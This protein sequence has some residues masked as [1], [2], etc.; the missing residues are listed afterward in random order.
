MSIFPVVSR[1]EWASAQSRYASFL[2][3]A[4]SCV[5]A[6]AADR[7]FFQATPLERAGLKPVFRENFT[8]GE[9][10]AMRYEPAYGSREQFDSYI[11][12]GA[13][14]LGQANATENTE[15][16]VNYYP[17]SDEPAVWTIEFDAW[18]TALRESR[19][20]VRPRRFRDGV[21]VRIAQPGE[22]T[23]VVFRNEP[24]GYRTVDY[25]TLT[26]PGRGWA[27]VV[28]S[29][30]VDAEKKACEFVSRAVARAAG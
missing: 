22:R 10:D 8:D 15:Q 27:H 30:R 3:V 25:G 9:L 6:P 12:P 20:L 21:H 24:G 4:L 7:N 18:P 19:V 29:Y 13:I 28:V 14:F 26:G 17:K 23:Q 11:Q 16:Q 2:I 1:A 5:S